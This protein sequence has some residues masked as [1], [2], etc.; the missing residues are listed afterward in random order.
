MAWVKE[1]LGLRKA[2]Q[3]APP[4]V[5]PCCQVIGLI[6]L[7]LD[8]SPDKWMGLIAHPTDVSHISMSRCTTTPPLPQGH[9]ARRRRRSTDREHSNLWCVAGTAR[10]CLAPGGWTAR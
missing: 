8:G 2:D 7:P 5:M 6:K 3:A 1:V 10:G 9:D 4:L